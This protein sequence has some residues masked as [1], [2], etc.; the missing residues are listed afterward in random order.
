MPVTTGIAVGAAAAAT[1]VD[2]VTVAAPP[3]VE[4]TRVTVPGAVGMMLTTQL[5][6]DGALV[7]TGPLHVARE[8][9]AEMVHGAAFT[10]VTALNEAGPYRANV[11]T[12][13]EFVEL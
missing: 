3:F 6:P 13:G 5:R 9:E 7:T 12:A 10:P 11:S 2:P 4:P 8:P 1:V